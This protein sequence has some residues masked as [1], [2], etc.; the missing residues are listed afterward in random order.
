MKIKLVVRNFAEKM[1]Q[2]HSTPH[3]H[4]MGILTGEKQIQREYI[5]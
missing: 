4:R 2:N 3:T 1:E 5:I